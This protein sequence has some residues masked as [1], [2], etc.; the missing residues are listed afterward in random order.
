[1]S[2][3]T[4]SAGTLLVGLENAI[5]WTDGRYFIQALDELKGSGIEMFKMRIPGW[6]SLLE[7]LKENAKAGETIAFDGKV[8]SVGEYK[9]FKKL[10]EENNINI[11]ID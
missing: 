7:W 3:F 11:K 10:E 8:F 4:G 9:D 2:G 6:P 1:M 5:L